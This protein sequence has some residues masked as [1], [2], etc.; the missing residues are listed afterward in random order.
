[1]NLIITGSQGSGKGTQAEKIAK[2]FG[3]L[4][5]QS[6]DIL[7]DLAKNDKRIRDMLAKGRLVPN[8]ETINYIESYIEGK[9]NNFD[10]IIFDGYPRTVDQY[11]LL[12]KWLSEKGENIDK[13][14]YL[15]ISDEE[16]VRRLSARRLCKNCEE[17][18]NLITK[19]PKGKVCDKC[20]GKLVT[21]NDDKPKAIKKRLSIFHQQTEPMLKIM[22][23]E[24][25]LLKIDGERPI[26]VIFEDILK[27]LK[28]I[29]VE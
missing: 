4:H 11:N 24:D 21:R 16:A 18:Y 25:L 29:N 17:I 7:R 13:V 2:K 19:L 14:I 22:K 27:K 5:V 8:Q 20:G 15:E 23:S 3:L 10:Q 9:Q 6:G 28:E 26:D 1:M 12:S